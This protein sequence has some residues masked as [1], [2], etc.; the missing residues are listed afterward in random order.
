MKRNLV[1]LA[2]VALLVFVIGFALASG[3]EAQESTP[4][5][6]PVDVVI[7]TPETPEATIPAWLMSNIVVVLGAVA[8]LIVILQT[9]SAS[10]ANKDAVEAAYEAMP[11]G[12]QEM[13]VSVLS[14]AKTIIDTANGAYQ[15]L[16]DV[17]DKQPNEDTPLG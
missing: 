11:P 10:K 3:A 12:V 1:T 5:P 15:F 16:E 2:L 14:I 7:E 9:R 13:V 8:A 6:A 4:E 17:T